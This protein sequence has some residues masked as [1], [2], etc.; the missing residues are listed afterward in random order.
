MAPFP[1]ALWH[2]QPFRL[3]EFRKLPVLDLPDDVGRDEDVALFVELD[4]SESGFPFCLP[5][6]IRDFDAVGRLRRGNRLEQKYGSHITVDGVRPYRL[7]ELFFVP[8][9]DTLGLLD[10]RL[11]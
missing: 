11:V 10:L 6:M 1:P 2:Q 3:P 5:D 4:R 7:P 8:L 9:N